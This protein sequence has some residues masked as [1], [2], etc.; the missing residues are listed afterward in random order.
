MTSE[1]MLD[2]CVKLTVPQLRTYLTC[3]SRLA[4]AYEQHGYGLQAEGIRNAAEELLK[5][6]N[7]PADWLQQMDQLEKQQAWR[8][9]P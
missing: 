6:L 4:E 1:M 9:A 3:M 5:H 2:G 7:L 8:Q